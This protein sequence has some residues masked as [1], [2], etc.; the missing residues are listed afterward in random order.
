MKKLLVVVLVL[1]SFSSFAD[2]CAWNTTSDTKSAKE[3]LEN[4]DVMLWCQNC[5]EKKPSNI[6][7]VREVII[8][9]PDAKL[10]EIKAILEYNKG[11]TSLD[12]AYTYVRT[13]SDIFTNLAQLVGCPS[14]GATTFIQTGKGKKKVAHYYDGAGNR[15]DVLTSSSD[16]QVGAITNTLAPKRYPASIAK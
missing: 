13:A 4:N 11:E 16:Y 6:F 5:D 14:H 3:L 7:A 15:V 8:G 10:R 12:L 2:Q 9:K 1:T